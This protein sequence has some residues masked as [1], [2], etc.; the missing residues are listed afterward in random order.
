MS[1]RLT[2]TPALWFNEC[3]YCEITDRG[4]E[5]E[6]LDKAH[7]L[8]KNFAAYHFGDFLTAEFDRLDHA[9]LSPI[10]QIE[11]LTAV[12]DKTGCPCLNP[13]IET[14]SEQTRIA[15]ETLT[16]PTSLTLPNESPTSPK[17]TKHAPQSSKHAPT[18]PSTILDRLKVG[19]PSARSTPPASRSTR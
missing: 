16:L 10:G 18:K 4:H 1:N 2:Q 5:R 11:I 3:K 9:V 17:P 8:C 12:H 14:I 7:K 6:L 15:Q 19:P 13:A